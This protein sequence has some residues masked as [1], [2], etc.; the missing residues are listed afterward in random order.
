MPGFESGLVLV[1]V[2]ATVALFI[3]GRRRFDVIAVGVLAAL[4]V[5]GLIR[6][7]QALHGF[8]S[9]A[10]A[11]VAAMFV[12]SAG[13]VRTGLVQWLAL[14]IDRLAGRTESRL[15][16]VLCLT[17][18]ALSAFIVNTATVAIFIPV[19]VVL[20]RSRKLPASR[21]LMPLSFASQFGGVCTLIGTST[22]ILVN[23]LAVSYGLDAFGL[24]EFAPLGLAMVGAGVV[25]LMVAGRWLLPTRR[26]EAQRVDKYRLAD[27]LAELRVKENSPLVGETW[28]RSGATRETEA[29]LIKLVRDEKAT[30]RP[31]ATRIR[32]GDILL[33]HGNVENLIGMQEKYGLELK[34]DVEMNDR[35]LSADDVKMVEVVI[36]PRSSLVGRTL[37]TFDFG[38]RFGGI[39][40]ALQRRGRILRERLS[41]IR[42]DAGDT[43]L[44]QCSEDDLGRMMRS[45]DLVVTNELT[46]LYIRKDRAIVA[47]PV[48]LLAV[49]LVALGVVPILV[50]AIVGAVAMVIGRCLN[51]EEAYR[52]ID[53]KVVFLLGGIIP[54]GLALDQSGGARWLADSVLVPFSGFG[55][56]AI[57]A[58]LYILT[59]VLTEFMSN[60]AAAV[61]LAPIALSLATS[62]GVSPRPFLVAITF[63]AS[64][65][66]A[67]PIGYQTNTMVF[68]PGGYRFTDYT[69]VG[70]PLN[71]IFW[72]LAVLLIPRL[73]PF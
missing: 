65:S 15:V 27:Y 7:E 55:P 39:V 67:T 10:T 64:T 3:A 22:N 56:L 26:G 18:A 1:I 60:T 51:I 17:V 14:R 29:E 45:S 25:Y 9:P 40:L 37:E 48:F 12:L 32:E 46:D 54:L 35:E 23:A 13:L 72:G 41:G 42:L 34:T 38:R 43:L 21:V 2:A 8:S 61:L 52:A 57:L 6:P 73:W 63:A 16:L 44:L 4:L 30:W 19:A 68:A 66:F 33:L 58:A 20:A 70:G 36:P 11:T 59:A 69:R 31:S 49:T 50:A 71:L 24:F 28:E 47:L 5:L 62:M 53:W